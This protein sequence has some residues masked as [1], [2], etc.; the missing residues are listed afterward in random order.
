MGFVCTVSVVVTR[1]DGHSPQRWLHLDPAETAFD[2]PLLYEAGWGKKLTYVIAAN[3]DEVVDVTKRYTKKYDE[4]LTRRTTVNEEWLA[5][6]VALLDHAQK[7]QIAHVSPQRLEVLW[8]CH[9]RDMRLLSLPF[10]W[11]AGADST[12]SF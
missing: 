2:T 8:S 3:K 4:V 7:Y 5:D 9:A 12:T 1:F 10:L 11:I 6:A